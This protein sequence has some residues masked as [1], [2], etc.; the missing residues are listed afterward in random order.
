M[1]DIVSDNGGYGEY[2]DY[3]ERLAGD[4][5]KNRSRLMKN[6]S[7]AIGEE[8]TDRQMQMIKLYYLDGLNMPEVARTLGVCVST[9]SRTIGRGKKR[10]QRCLRYG[11]EE[12]LRE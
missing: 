7:A 2:R 11:A 6:L 8:L 1:R 5:S 4:N 10:L 12:F 9:V 3:F